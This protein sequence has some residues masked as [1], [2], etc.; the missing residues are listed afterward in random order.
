MK[1]PCV[2]CGEE[3]LYEVSDPVDMRYGY[4]EGVGQYCIPCYCNSI[5]T[6]S[7]PIEMVRSTSNDADLG[8]KVRKFYNENGD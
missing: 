7:I 6:I 3:S 5:K 2:K 8:F 4:I 1:D